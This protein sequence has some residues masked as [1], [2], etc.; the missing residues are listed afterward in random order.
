MFS[1][2]LTAGLIGWLA[3]LVYLLACLLA[4][5]Q[6]NETNDERPPAR[7]TKLNRPIHTIYYFFQSRRRR[8]RRRGYRTFVKLVSQS[9]SQSLHPLACLLA[10]NCLSVCMY[11]CM[12]GCVCVCST[13]AIVRFFSATIFGSGRKNC[14]QIVA[15]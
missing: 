1:P 3:V 2:Q 6:V 9:D 12:D 4:V 7:H 13:S 5:F 15:S 8:R 11:V 10:C 14:M